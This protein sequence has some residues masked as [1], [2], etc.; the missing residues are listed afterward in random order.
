MKGT[1]EIS[2]MFYILLGA[3]YM[4]V[5]IYKTHWIIHLRSVFHY[6][7]MYLCVSLEAYFYLT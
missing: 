3:G 7:Y 4:D 6:M 1:R 2:E 5:H